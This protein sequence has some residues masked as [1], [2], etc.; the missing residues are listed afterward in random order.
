MKIRLIQVY[1]EK[2]SLEV[3][4]VTPL[5]LRLIEEIGKRGRELA[6]PVLKWSCV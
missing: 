4:M 6:H 2:M 1:N 5:K 3:M